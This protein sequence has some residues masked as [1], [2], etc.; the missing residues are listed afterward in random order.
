MG[1][2]Q[3]LHTA[4]CDLF[5]APLRCSASRSTE[6][7]SGRRSCELSEVLLRCQLVPPRCPGRL[8]IHLLASYPPHPHP[9]P[10]SSGIQE[11]GGGGW[12]KGRLGNEYEKRQTFLVFFQSLEKWTHPHPAE[13]RPVPPSFG[14]ITVGSVW[15]AGA[16]SNRGHL[17][18]LSDPRRRTVC[19][20][21]RSL[22]QPHTAGGF[23]GRSGLGYHMAVLGPAVMKYESRTKECCARCAQPRHVSGAPAA[24]TP[25]ASVLQRF[26]HF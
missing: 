6:V 21:I 23:Q 13:P 16:T 22:H 17:N 24:G 9:H 2:G 19:C 7:F 1:G 25:G 11:K 12:G 18:S 14:N 26:H 10:S 4:S 15:S 5:S 3:D 20:L 8:Q